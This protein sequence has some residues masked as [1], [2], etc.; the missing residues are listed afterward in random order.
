MIT[1]LKSR[2]KNSPYTMTGYARLHN[3]KYRTMED[4]ING[5]LPK[6]P[7]QISIKILAQL[8]ADG[9]YIGELPH[10]DGFNPNINFGYEV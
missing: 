9:F 7:T 6:K 1:R 10:E 8:K 3:F 4:I 2:F 5:K